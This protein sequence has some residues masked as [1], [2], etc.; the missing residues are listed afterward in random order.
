M[1]KILRILW[2]LMICLMLR[3]QTPFWRH[4]RKKHPTPFDQCRWMA[5]C[6]ARSQSE[7]RERE[8]FL[9]ILAHICER[10]ARSCTYKCR[11]AAPP[12]QRELKQTTLYIS[13][14]DVCARIYKTEKIFCGTLQENAALFLPCG[15]KSII[16]C[17]S[18]AVTALR[19]QNN[20][21]S[22]K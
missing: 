7:E 21:I 10:R 1:I 6:W 19:Q 14:H 18:I 12:Q 13:Q 20:E 17:F 3:V 9:P 22:R 4:T 16:K 2:W 15:L 5:G 11:K 8:S